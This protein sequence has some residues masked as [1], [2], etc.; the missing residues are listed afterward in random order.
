MFRVW[1]TNEEKMFYN[2]FVVSST[3]Q[4]YYI[5]NR[6][7]DEIIAQKINGT[8]MKKTNKRDN[9]GKRIYVGDILEW[10][11]SQ[12][13]YDMFCPFS[14]NEKERREFFATKHKGIVKENSSSWLRYKVDNYSLQELLEYHDN[15]K[16]IGNIFENPEL[17]KEVKDDKYNQQT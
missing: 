12:Y 16:I 7:N 14:L 4:A 6:D 13:D 3:G 15:V 9:Q 2:N 17:L 1:D 10:T 11:N 5:I 8:V